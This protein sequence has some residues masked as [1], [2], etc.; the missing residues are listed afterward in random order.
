M[1]A[2]YHSQK[3][4]NG[5]GSGSEDV[6]YAVAE[7][8]RILSP[9]FV[10]RRDFQL[11]R[12]FRQVRLGKRAIGNVLLK[13]WTGSAIC[14]KLVHSYLG[15]IES[16]HS[17]FTHMCQQLD[18]ITRPLEAAADMIMEINGVNEMYNEAVGLV[19]LSR[20][21]ETGLAELS[22]LAEHEGRE[23]V[24]EGYRSSSLFFQ[25]R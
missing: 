23:R 12:M 20:Q 5:L 3:H 22:Y 21:L 11:Q 19:R 14:E 18:Q 24:G 2:R 7:L 10:Y 6:R 15:N 16:D 13:D 1:R 17:I 8:F 25:Y 4:E 9:D